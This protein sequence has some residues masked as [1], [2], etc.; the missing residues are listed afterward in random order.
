M[1]PKFPEF[2]DFEIQDRDFIQAILNKYQPQTSE[3]TF[4]NLFIWRNH[5]KFQ[6]TTYQNNLVVLC[7]NNGFYF[8]SPIGLTPRLELIRLLLK[9]LKT[10]KGEKEPRIEK[11][12]QRLKKEIEEAKDLLVEQTRDQF[13]YVYRTSDLIEL[14]GRK[15]HRKKNH[16]NSFLKTYQYE[17]KVLSENYIK[18]C[19][20]LTEK[21][22]KLFRCEEDMNL[23]DELEAIRETLSN[24]STLKL[25]GG[26][27]LIN[28]K[29]EAFTLGELLNNQTAVVH[30]EK[31][32]PEIKGAYAI[33][34]QQFCEK[35]WHGVPYIN[36][37]QDLGE[38]GL[39][40][41]KLSYNPD[42]LVEK[43]RIR[44]V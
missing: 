9:W 38:P 35:T 30:I 11:A 4:T 21:W 3:W 32:N 36:R 31:A 33:I 5:Y 44:L 41:A 42:H 18:E 16:V 28:N 8:L 27:I 29:V 23:L 25:Q 43:Y 15:F 6:W 24:F 10:D 40:Q 37:E 34:N 39:R 22:C 20:E 13:D 19:L 17:Y 26:V 12:D 1:Q 7:A 2:K 14:A